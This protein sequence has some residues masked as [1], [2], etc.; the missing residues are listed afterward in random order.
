MDIDKDYYAILG[1]LPGIDAVAL[2]AVYTALMK[3]FHPDT[4]TLN[5]KEAEEKAKEINQAYA[6][7]SDPV[8]RAEYDKA[9]AESNKKYGDYRDDQTASAVGSDDTQLLRDWEIVVEHYPECEKYRKQLY[10]LSS[11][12]AKIF[13]VIIV[14]NKW[15][16]KSDI[17]ADNLK[18]KYLAF[19]FGDSER[20]HRFVLK[21]KS[22]RYETALLEISDYVRVIGT[23]SDSELDKFILKIMAKYKIRKF[24]IYNLDV[25]DQENFVI[26]KKQNTSYQSFMKAILLMFLILGLLSYCIP[27]IEP[28]RYW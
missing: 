7:L 24:E 9:R 5:R 8:K 10:D 12:L 25:I 4:T 21:L 27:K 23:P 16:S 13:Q 19:Y 6:I 20:I 1:V 15:A 2:K 17:I 18:Q 22:L 26:E 14:A 3:K 11:S 28:P